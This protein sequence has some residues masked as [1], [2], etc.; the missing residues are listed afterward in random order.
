MK[1]ALIV[2]TAMIIVTYIYHL[3]YAQLLPSLPWSITSDY[4]PRMINKNNHIWLWDFHKGID[5]GAP[6]GSEIKALV[7]GGLNIGGTK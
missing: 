3:L 6:S 1:K 5:Y 2:S 7:G 4:G